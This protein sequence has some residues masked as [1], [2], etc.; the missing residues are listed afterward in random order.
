MI[1]IGPFPIKWLHGVENTIAIYPW[2]PLPPNLINKGEE[3]IPEVQLNATVCFP[4]SIRI[5]QVYEKIV[6]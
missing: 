4:D 1:D 6:L 5:G 2:L 3:W